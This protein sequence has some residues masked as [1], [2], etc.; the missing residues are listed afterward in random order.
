MLSVMK[1]A[2]AARNLGRPVK[3]VNELTAERG[4]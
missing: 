3:T 2:D 4:R 1:S